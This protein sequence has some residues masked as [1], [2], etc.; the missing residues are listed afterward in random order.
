MKILPELMGRKNAAGFK[1][2]A[3]FFLL[4]P[5]TLSLYA[6][7]LPFVVGGELYSLNADYSTTAIDFYG[8]ATFVQRGVSKS[9]KNDFILVWNQQTKELL[10]INSNNKVV[11]KI[12]LD[13]ASV[14]MNENFVFT[15]SSSFD[16]NRGFSF[17][18]YK[19]SYSRFLNRISLK[20]L[21]QGNID[22]FVSD[23]VF[24]KDGI[25]IGGGTR[26]N[27]RHIVYKISKQG[28]HKSFSMDKNG[29]F[30]RLLNSPVS[31]DVMYAFLS[32][33]DKSKASPIIY[34]FELN[35][36]SDSSSAKKIDLLKDNKFPVNFDCFFG[37][38]FVFEDGII[39]PASI[40][41]KISF[42]KLNSNNRIERVIPYTNG[43]NFPLGNG[44]NNDYIY[45]ARDPLLPDS[46]YG[47][48][49]FNGQICTRIESFN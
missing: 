17:S 6:A 33:R 41:E 21:W 39:L 23:C 19:I 2:L 4:I 31:E 28:I 43:C 13:A 20:T 18:L 9:K 47:L 34:S 25:C 48:S 46:F 5:I 1:K 15:Q 45:I 35:K 12:S 49:S 7:K 40:E 8:P 24:L 38:G 11:S 22:C 3:A 32:G 44:N 16:E 29:D 42:I 14:F 10:N 37:Y 36:L 26:D 30:I 27:L